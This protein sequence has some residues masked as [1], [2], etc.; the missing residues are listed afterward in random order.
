MTRKF[1]PLR[2]FFSDKDGRLA[3]MQRPNPPLLVWFVFAVLGRLL[4]QGSIQSTA[5]GISK[6]A[7]IIWAVLEVYSGDSYFRRTLGFV[8]LIF[9][10]A[11]LL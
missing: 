11:S 8:V 4:H 5:R 6:V 10:I 1:T 9:S 7:I 2:T 3:I